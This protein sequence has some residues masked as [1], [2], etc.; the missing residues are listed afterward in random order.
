MFQTIFN[1]CDV[2]I[3]MQKSK[4]WSYFIFNLFNLGS[5]SLTLG[6]VT[7]TVFWLF[8]YWCVVMSEC[9]MGT[10]WLSLWFITGWSG[11]KKS[12]DLDYYWGLLGRLSPAAESC[13]DSTEPQH[14]QHWAVGDKSKTLPSNLM[15]QPVGIY[16][17]LKLTCDILPVI[18]NFLTFST[19]MLLQTDAD[20]SPLTDRR[21]TDTSLKTS[22]IFLSITNP[23]FRF[24]KSL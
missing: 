15:W 24:F 7:L 22:T 21:S 10:Q 23:H 6:F 4:F 18:P 11:L 16:S 3:E 19:N 12:V 2:K 5:N 13:T 1:L 8:Y 14:P 17:C 9:M 20:L